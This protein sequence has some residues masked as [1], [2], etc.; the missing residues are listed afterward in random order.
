MKLPWIRRGEK[1]S[2]Q[3]TT[4]LISGTKCA[5]CTSGEVLADSQQP[6]YRGEGGV[7]GLFVAD[8]SV[9]HV[10]VD[11]LGLVIGVDSKT[12]S[13]HLVEHKAFQSMW[14]QPLKGVN[15]F[16]N[17]EKQLTRLKHK[18]LKHSNMKTL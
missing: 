5:Q 7:V 1:S 6:N 17:V 15:A 10:F 8:D 13:V 3:I 16:I 12:P 18:T 11:G 9:G 4:L 2:E 14:S